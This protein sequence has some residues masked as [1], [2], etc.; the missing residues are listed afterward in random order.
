M[1]GLLLYAVP[2]LPEIR[3]GD[4]LAALIA[5]GCESVNLSI[6]SG[7]VVV[8]AQKVVSKCEGR[9]IALETIV[10][11]ERAMQIAAETDKDPRLVQAILDESSRVLRTRRGLI[12][13][14]HRLGFICANAGIDRSNVEQRADGLTLV[15]LLPED[16]D[17]SANRIRD[18]LR[19]H[20]GVHVAVL[21]IDSHGRPFRNGAVGVTIG[22]AGM[23]PLTCMVGWPDRHGYALKVTSVATADELAGAASHLMGQSS[24]SCPVVVVRG[25][26]YVA[27]NGRTDE[28][29]REPEK[30]L[31]R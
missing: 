11:S 17:M 19:Y 20:M 15:T 22:V 24:E 30:D 25:A 6:E 31:F 13:V 10:P 8:V 5:R 29:L 4:N 12:I 3:P 1:N 14:E 9:L 23:H 18:G 7:D 27:G 16:P 21:I 28:L 26:T 2:D